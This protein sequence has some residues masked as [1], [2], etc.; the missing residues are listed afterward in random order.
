MQDRRQSKRQ[1]AIR[2]G[3]W[4]A[5]AALGLVFLTVFPSWLVLFLSAVALAIGLRTLYDPGAVP[6][7]VYHSVS[8]APEWLPWANNISVR[9][10][11]FEAHL[12]VIKRNG[13]TVISSQDLLSARAGGSQLPKRAVVLNFDDGYLDNHVAAVPILRRHGMPA[14]FFVLTDFIDQ[15]Q[16]IR[17]QLGSGAS[18]IWDGYMNAAEL[19]ELDA[20][21]LFEVASHGTD[22]GRVAVAPGPVSHLTPGNWQRH[23]PWLWSQTRSNKANWYNAKDPDFPYGT[24]VPETDSALCAASWNAPDQRETE[25]EMQDRVLESLTRARRS[26]SDLLGREITF[27]CWPFDRVTPVALELARKAGFTQFTGGRGEN[28][29]GEDPTVLSRVHVNDH[30]AGPNTPLWVEALVFRARL[31]VAAGA[32]WWLP[33]SWTAARLRSRRFAFE[34]EPDDRTQQDSVI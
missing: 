17:P 2:S 14:T 26:L 33:V 11:V 22:H 29:V 25:R 28:R 1:R 30:S 8:D 24:P 5:F 10:N 7:M 3:F 21:P 15:S 18:L 31:G 20:D 12:K 16:D 9:P 6:V 27:F 19:R 32:F 23:A 4:I 34:H 13:W